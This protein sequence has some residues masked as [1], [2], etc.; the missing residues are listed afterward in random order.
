MLVYFRNHPDILE[1]YQINVQFIQMSIVFSVFN[2]GCQFALLYMEANSGK[3]PL[4]PFI[5]MC[6]AGLAE[7]VPLLDQVDTDSPQ[8]FC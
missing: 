1:K 2:G 8:T 7:Y 4:L 6:F 3:K 5:V